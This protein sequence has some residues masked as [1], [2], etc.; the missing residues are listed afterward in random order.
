M[1]A[2]MAAVLR[3]KTTNDPEN[4]LYVKRQEKVTRL[5]CNGVAHTEPF[6]LSL[7]FGDQTAQPD[8]ETM[9]NTLN[10]LV[11]LAALSSVVLMSGASAQEAVEGSGIEALISGK[12]VYLSTPYGGEF[13]LI[14]NAD[15]T[16]T[17]D[18]TELGLARFF[19]PRETG[20]WWV[21]GANL[22]QQ[23]PT[24]YRGE[25]SCFTIEKTG[26]TTI[27]WVRDDGQSGS[28]RIEG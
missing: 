9:M 5:A 13:P 27:T 1:V 19:A 14:Y 15:G 28:A 26:D 11:A 18:G 22:C 8:L 6:A 25:V 4:R 24:W 2:S 16:V 21:E 10:K 7:R 20:K 23:F 17:G 12:R 3:S